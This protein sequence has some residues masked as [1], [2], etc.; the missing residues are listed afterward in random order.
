[1]DHLAGT[2]NLDLLVKEGLKDLK[3]NE[4]TLDLQDLWAQVVNLDLLVLV[5]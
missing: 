4:E 3:E 2:E 5:V 1:M